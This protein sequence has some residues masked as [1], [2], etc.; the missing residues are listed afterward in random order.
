MDAF[1]KALEK[2]NELLSEAGVLIKGNYFTD[3]T[4]SGTA[5][6]IS[7]LDFSEHDKMLIDDKKE[8]LQKKIKDLRFDIGKSFMDTTDDGFALFIRGMMNGISN[9]LDILKGKDIDEN[10]RDVFE[11]YKTSIVDS[12]R[13]HLFCTCLKSPIEELER[14]G[15]RKQDEINCLKEEIYKVKEL[16]DKCCEDNAKQKRENEELRHQLKKKESV[17]I[18]PYEPIAV[19][20]MLIT[21]TDKCSDTDEIYNIYD[22]S[23]LRQIAEHLLVYCN[24]NK[25]EG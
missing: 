6:T 9:C 10:I 16:N 12:S 13:G 7:G 20:Q 1:Q 3:N 23:D 14:E 25:D 2:L 5:I 11:S 8:K 24:N 22:I 18:L 17:S 4:K 15:K 19:A 21:A